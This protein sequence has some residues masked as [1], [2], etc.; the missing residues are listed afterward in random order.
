MVWYLQAQRIV[1]YIKRGLVIAVAVL[2]C[3]E[4]DS[5]LWGRGKIY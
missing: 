1:A 4:A 5:R 2:V 3:K